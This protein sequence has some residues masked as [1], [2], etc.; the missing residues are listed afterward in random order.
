MSATYAVPTCGSPV[1]DGATR[2]RT[3]NGKLRS[4]RALAALP[5]FAADE[6]DDLRER[7]TRGKDLT[8]AERLE[9][10]R[11]VG[12]NRSAAEKHDVAGIL[13]SQVLE[14][15]RKECHVRAGEDRET[16]PVGVFLYGGLNHLLRG[17]K[18]AGVDHFHSGVT[19]RASY[20]LR[21]AIVAVEAGLGH[22]D[23]KRAII[24][25]RD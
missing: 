11:V 6:L 21:A 24:R 18:Q 7:S 13:R 14:D 15:G 10:A 4:E 12:R 5:A 20:D 2:V 23:S 19:E 16:D 25:H 3:L 1:G 22:D 17:L 8:H 9:F